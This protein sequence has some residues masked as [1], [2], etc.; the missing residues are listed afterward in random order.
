MYWV[1]CVGC[2]GV[3]FVGDVFCV[4]G[5]IGFGLCYCIGVVVC[6]LFDGV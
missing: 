5:W 3:V 2:G 6:C 4:V 1:D